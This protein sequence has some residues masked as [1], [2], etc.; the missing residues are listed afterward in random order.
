MKKLLII[1]LFWQLAWSTTSNLLTL[2]VE[3]VSVS[4]NRIYSETYILEAAPVRT[5][6]GFRIDSITMQEDIR[7]IMALG[8]FSAVAVAYEL[9]AYGVR[10]VYEVT[11]APVLT[12]VSF[13]EKSVFASSRILHRWYHQ[14]DQQLNYLLLD[15]DI[16]RLNALYQREGF[17]LS[18][19]TGV[20]LQGSTLNVVCRE[21]VINEI[22]VTGNVYTKTELIRRELLSKPGDVYNAK[23]MNESRTKIFSLGYFSL[24]SLPEIVPADKPGKVDVRLY[25]KEKKKSNLNF[26]IGVTSR[27]Q[28]AFAKLNLLNLFNTGE[29]LFFSFQSGYEYRISNAYPKLDYRFRY[30]N[31]WFGF[32]NVSFGYTKYLAINYEALRNRTADTDELLQIRRD[33]FST[34]WGFPLPFG[35]QYRFITE[36]KDEVVSEVGVS[37]RVKYTNRSV[38][39]TYLYTGVSMISGT[40]IPY[41][42]ELF[43]LRL[44]QGGA[45]QL[46]QAMRFVLGGVEFSRVDTQ[47]SRY[48]SLAEK[49]HIISTTYRTGSFVSSRQ[50]NV[51]EGEEYTVGGG[52][53]VRGY[54]DTA[55]FATGPKLAV[56]NTEYHYLFSDTLQGVLFYDWGNAFTD[57]NVSMK[58]FKSGYGF[59][60]RY[61]TMIGPLRFDLGRGEKYW[62]FHF[63]LGWTF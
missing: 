45:I 50:S 40:S 62:V 17:S 42:G 20:E 61:L 48:V 27:E 63:G 21:P 19:V 39:G 16:A 4:G 28:F 33:G 22:S 30:F 3:S 11:E 36:Y 55:P 6:P 37:P 56:I 54:A 23:V 51:L 14:P 52:T 53:T 26:G 41:D 9:G 10:V 25:V 12:G 18:S 35:S 58:D 15:K 2:P 1:C 60:L 44:E 7:R 24:V 38:A 29:Q 32:Q 13:S 59:G 49:N 31:P 57:V 34:D 47:Y 5:R 46:G 8:S 43:K